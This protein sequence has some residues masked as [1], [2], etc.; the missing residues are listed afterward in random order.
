MDDSFGMRGVQRVGDLNRK[1][2]QLVNFG[3]L[4]LNAMLERLAVEILHSDERLTVALINVIDRANVGMV[5]SGRGARLALKTFERLAIAGQFIGQEFKGDPAA[6]LYILGF[7]DHTHAPA[8]QLLQDAVMGNDL[9]DHK[10][11]ALRVILALE[12]CRE[13]TS[14]PAG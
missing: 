1:I 6:E 4:Y 13:S 9:A 2:Q 14:V 3:P 8:A 10:D 5:Q 11:E 7:V 12:Q